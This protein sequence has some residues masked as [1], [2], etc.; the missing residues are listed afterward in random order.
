M[1]ENHVQTLSDGRVFIDYGP[2]SMVLAAS[3]GEKMLSALCAAAFE[4]IEASLRELAPALPILRRF[5]G[6]FDPGVLTGLPR[7]MADAVLATKESTLTPM[8]AVAGAVADAAADWIFDRGA[9]TVTANNGGDIALRLRPGRS[10]RLGILPDLSGGGLGEIVTIRA[11]DGVGG[12]CT[13]GL[14]GR[15]FTRGIA[16]AVTVFSARCVQADACATHIANCSYVA[17]PRVHTALAGD[18]D[19]ESDIASLRVVT[20]TDPLT[21]E[22]IARGLGQM[23]REAKRQMEAGNLFCAA[24]HIQWKRMVFPA[25]YKLFNQ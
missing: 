21:G 11:E 9:E 13:S 15:S 24:A 22:E 2:V 19:P 5:P 12:V 8:A 17:S 6:T 18:I 25:N 10:L 1:N 3:D 4:V 23:E 14:G 16:S 20:G 7:R